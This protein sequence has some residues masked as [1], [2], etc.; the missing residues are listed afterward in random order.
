MERSFDV[1]E[2]AASNEGAGGQF[3]S[4][5][6]GLGAGVSIGNAV[7]NNLGGIINMNPNTPPPINPAPTYYVYLNGQQIGGQTIQQISHYAQ[8]GIITADTLVWTPGMTTWAK[9]STVPQLASLFS[10]IVPPPIN[11]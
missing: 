2:K 1:L 5:G 7:G 10:P 6:V 9:I 8:Q 4:M 11:P 3:A